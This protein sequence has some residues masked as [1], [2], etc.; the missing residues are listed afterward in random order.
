[1]AGCQDV[2]PT[3]SSP[4]R[5]GASIEPGTIHVARSNT[6][7]ATASRRYADGKPNE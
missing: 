4:S 7:A 3:T 5:S 1:L 6:S 2:Q